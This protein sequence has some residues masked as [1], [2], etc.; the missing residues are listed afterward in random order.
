[1]Q[2]QA[3]MYLEYSTG[4]TINATVGGNAA[5]AEWVFVI[6]TLRW[7]RFWAGE[8]CRLKPFNTI[9]SNGLI[10]NTDVLD[11]DLLKIRT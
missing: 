9:G 8:H 1:M 10:V 7:L 11:V 6:I 3:D 5:T 4:N 2:M